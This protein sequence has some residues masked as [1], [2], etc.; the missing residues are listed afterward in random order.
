[1]N[2]KVLSI[3]LGGSLVLTL[4]VGKAKSI[5]IN[6][7]FSIE[8]SL[9]NSYQY[10]ILNNEVKKDENVDSGI[11]G[12]TA[13]DLGLNFHP[14]KRDEV[15]VTLSYAAGNEWNKL[16]DD[17]FH[18]TPNGDDLEDD[19]MQING[20][21][22]NNLLEAWYKREFNLPN[23]VSLGVTLGIIDATAYI[24]DNAYANDELTQFMNDAF[25]NNP[26]ANLP[27]YDLG[28]VVELSKGN[29]DVKALAMNPKECN[30]Y[31]LQVAYN[32]NTPLGEGTYRVYGFITSKDF[33]SS[34]SIGKKEALKGVGV[35]ID[36]EL[37]NNVGGFLRLGWQSDKAQVD[38]TG[39]YSAGVH[40]NGKLWER[41]KD[42]A[43]IGIGYLNGG[44]KSPVSGMWIGE[45]YVKFSLVEKEALKTDLTVDYQYMKNRESGKDY[46]ANFLG[47]RL[48]TEF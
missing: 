14:T 9:T 6:K 1:M 13:L 44:K 41:E 17:V 12:A 34:S 18:V 2:K 33:P 37:F 36:Q 39:F 5:D 42:E 22:R 46:T 11:K 35:S 20:R 31:A 27:S 38:F 15:Q 19:L 48:N 28:G 23:D 16:G 29:V 45:A 8:G 21:N 7:S 24:D 3:L 30:Y 32:L 25:V 26:V 40:L 4:G 47:L 43:G 10:A